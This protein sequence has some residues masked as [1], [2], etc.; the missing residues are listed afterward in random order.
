MRESE[1]LPQRP[2]DGETGEEASA[3]ES[4]FEGVVAVGAATAEP[5]GFTGGVEPGDRMSVESRHTA[6]EI[7]LDAAERLARERAQPDSDER[8]GLRVEEPMPASDP[9]EPVTTV[10]ASVEL[11]PGATE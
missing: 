5:G 11:W 8:T 9:G 4:P 3:E 1:A 7:R 2:R 6:S 10:T